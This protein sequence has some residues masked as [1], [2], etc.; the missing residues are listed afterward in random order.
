MLHDLTLQHTTLKALAAFGLR[1]GGMANTRRL[2]D[3]SRI[4]GP[5][6][7]QSTVASGAFLDIGAFCNLSGGQIN[8]LCAGRYCSIADGVAIGLHEHP[9]D[10]L[11]T[12]RTAYFPEVHD[13][14]H[15]MLGRS[16][17]TVPGRITGPTNTCPTTTI[18]PDV[19]IGQGAFLKSGVT[20]GAGA[21]IG[22]RTTVLKDVP[23]Y[24]IVVG[25]PARVVRFRFSD[26]LIERLLDCAW[27]QYSVYDL[28]DIP[29]N[30]PATAIDRI[31]ERRAAGSLV[32]FAGPVFAPSELTDPAHV[33]TRVREA[34]QAHAPAQR[35]E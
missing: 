34:L 32:P 6:S 8:N 20:I 11:T 7:I 33:E 26:A 30:D 35:G 5:T 2:A 25:T 27:W 28:L 1:L 14:D 24:A 18:G 21:V 31:A 4:E 22:A 9:T 10:W 17:N 19:W 3:H 15:L 29:L 13:W 23:P 16:A 12:S